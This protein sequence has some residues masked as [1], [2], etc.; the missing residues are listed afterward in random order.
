[1]SHAVIR[2]I[3]DGI[4]NNLRDRD[5][6]ILGKKIRREEVE[7]ALRSS[8]CGKAAGLDKI[9]YEMWKI[10]DIKYKSRKERSP[11]LDVIGMM[12]SVFQD[13]ELYGIEEG[14][15]FAEGWICSLYKKNEK[16]RVE[17]YRPITLLNS[18]YKVFTK[19][20]TNRLA[21]IGPKVIKQDSYKDAR[22][23][24]KSD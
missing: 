1:M 15:H 16:N 9:P 6:E 12:T 13:I 20:I 11:V 2:D 22:L 10:L 4:E 19:A 23:G 18:D 24:T 7:I 3:L 14:T 8:Q 21:K 5:K 17:N